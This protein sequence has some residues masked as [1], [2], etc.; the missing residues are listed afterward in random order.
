MNLPESDPRRKKIDVIIQASAG[1]ATIT[2][3]LLTFG[4]KQESDVRVVDPR[5]QV[6]S[7]QKVLGRLLGDNI[8]VV[9]EAHGTPGYIRIDPDQ[10]DQVIMN[11]AINARDAMPGG[12]ELHFDVRN[13]P[14][15]T[16]QRVNA[17]ASPRATT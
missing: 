8:K 9:S 14:S 3:R 15:T 17:S 7:V 11:L 13:T 10:L 2:R 6:T 5:E 4:R 16:R 12:G 1:A